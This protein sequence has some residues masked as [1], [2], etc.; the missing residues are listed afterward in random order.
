MTRTD[1]ALRCLLELYH[2]S[3]WHESVPSVEDLCGTIVASK[4]YFM[5]YA[6]FM[7]IYQEIKAGVT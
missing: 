3:F 7:E 5:E 1:D 2:I 6:R 4:K